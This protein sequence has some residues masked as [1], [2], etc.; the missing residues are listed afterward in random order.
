VDIL[1][2]ALYWALWHAFY[3]PV[4]KC[5]KNPP[6]KESK[7]IIDHGGLFDAKSNQQN[8]STNLVQKI[9]LIQARDKNV[10]ISAIELFVIRPNF[11]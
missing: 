11:D 7:L 9:L 4:E 6:L 2:L 5:R 8:N 10:Q 3:V 1:S